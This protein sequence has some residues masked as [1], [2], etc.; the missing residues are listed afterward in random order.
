MK[1]GQTVRA[2]VWAKWVL[3]G[4][5]LAAFTVPASAQMTSSGGG[6][7]TSGGG[8]G[9]GL[10]GSGGGASS[11]RGGSSGSSGGGTLIF[12]S[13]GTGISGSVTGS[14]PISKTNNL[15]PYYSSPMAAGL[16][17]NVTLKSQSGVNL[18]GASNTSGT[19]NQASAI[20]TAKG[21]FGVPLYAATNTSSSSG[22]KGGT[23][24]GSGGGSIS[25]NNGT[26]FSSQGTRRVA[27][28]MTVP[29]PELFANRPGFQSGGNLGA[30]LQN[31]GA[32][33]GAKG[34][35]VVMD[36]STYVLQ[37]S[38]GTDRERRLAEQMLRLEPGV[39]D[40]RN[41]IQVVPPSD[42]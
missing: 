32:F 18:N 22:G 11:G 3:T 8:G 31:S 28:Y 24:G 12:G 42:K 5:A 7:F 29:D 15:A 35:N 37:G 9:S 26:G 27:Q 36:G 6:G 16:A 14:S 23:A 34:F 21:T 41:E 13:A 30:N 2:G 38:V 4:V 40:V 20:L 19:A 33:K 39:H 25:T 10:G 17:S 1:T